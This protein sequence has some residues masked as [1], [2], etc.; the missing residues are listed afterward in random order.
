MIREFKKLSEFA[1]KHKV[2]LEPKALCKL[3]DILMGKEKPT[4]EMLDKL[5]LLAGFQNWESL[6]KTFE[7]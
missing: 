3:T 1:S 6:K 5:A 4:R 7:E 2:K